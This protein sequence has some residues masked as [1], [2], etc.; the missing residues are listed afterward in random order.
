MK[1]IFAILLIVA[2]GVALGV[3]IAMLKIKSA[4]WNPAS[5]EGKLPAGTSSTK[6]EGLRGQPA[7]LS[8]RS[9]ESRRHSGNPLMAAW[10]VH[11]VQNDRMG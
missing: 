1:K 6:A 5:D 2:L 8:E 3:G 7:R 10:I 4:P 11:C 9:E